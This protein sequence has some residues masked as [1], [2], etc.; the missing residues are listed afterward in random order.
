MLFSNGLANAKT[1]VLAV[2]EAEVLTTGE[3]SGGHGG[4]SEA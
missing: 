3:G 1:A 4:S 2:G